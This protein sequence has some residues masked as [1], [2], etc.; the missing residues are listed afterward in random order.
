M[1]LFFCIADCFY[2]LLLYCCP[3]GI[4]LRGAQ[5]C[6]ELYCHLCFRFWGVWFCAHCKCSGFGWCLPSVGG[7][8]CYLLLLSVGVSSCQQLVHGAGFDAA[9]CVGGRMF[10]FRLFWFSEYL[11]IILQ[12]QAAGF[13]FGSCFRECCFRGLCRVFHLYTAPLFVLVCFFSLARLV[14]V[15]LAPIRRQ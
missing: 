9:V 2:V 13:Y 10:I 3:K 7:G 11:C 8:W 14:F 1:L 4:I 6:I 15:R 12:C 5:H